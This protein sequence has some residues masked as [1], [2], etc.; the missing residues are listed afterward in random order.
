[1]AD[2][3]SI[4]GEGVS[5][6]DSPKAQASLPA[7]GRGYLHEIHSQGEDRA[8]ALAFALAQADMAD[9]GAI[10]ALRARGRSRLP[11]M[12]SGDGLSLLGIQP[13]RLTIVET[14]SEVD[15]LRAGLEAARCPGMALVLM[16]S[17][18]C[19]VP[20]DLTASRRLLLAAE[21][22][23]ACIILLRG[24]AEPRSS[25]A[26]TRWI[27]RSA[28]S[29]PLEAGAPGLPAIEA[30]LLRCRSRA[31]GGRWRLSWDAE[32]GQFRD[33][34]YATPLPGTLVSFSCLRTDADD[35]GADR[36]QVA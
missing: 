16:E 28:P 9:T 6:R 7:L 22:S 5:G 14:R 13:S 33:A 34:P 4:S 15:M 12:F 8:A 3:V 2:S 36:R 17:E 10:F 24:D 31:A 1:M 11:T 18:G 19:F 23:R 32:H 26:Q 25:G 27:V 30:E 21:A 35:D 20:Y 29:V